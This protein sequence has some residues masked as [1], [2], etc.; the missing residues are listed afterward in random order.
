MA[1]HIL[2]PMDDSAASETAL[3]YAIETHPD[4]ALTILHVI[5]APSMSERTGLAFEE[6]VN[7]ELEARAEAIFQRAT[8]IAQRA[9]FDGDLETTVGIGSPA[10]SIVEHAADADAIVIGSQGDD[11]TAQVLLGSVAETV[12]RRASV[13]VTI[14]R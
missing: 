6:T 5:G 14:V 1:S 8:D 13:P 12:S 2:V 4:A 11:E 9:G 7:E 3:E 10:Q